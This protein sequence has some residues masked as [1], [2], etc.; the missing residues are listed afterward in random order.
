VNVS[1]QTDNCVV[2]ASAD[3]K[4]IGSVQYRVRQMPDPIAT[5]GGQKS[6]A[7]VNAGTLRAQAGV[8][9]GIEN[10]PLPLRYTVTRFTVIATDPNSGDL[11]REVVNGNA[12]SSRAKQIMGGLQSG[13]IITFEDIQC[14][15]PNGQVIKLPALLYNIN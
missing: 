3:G 11:I 14:Q 13:D 9:A 15:K 12:F 1:Q 4:V 5:V 7:Y 2:T 8:A 6:G 10:F